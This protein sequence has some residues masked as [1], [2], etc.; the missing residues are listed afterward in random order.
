MKQIAA[1]V[2]TGSDLL[3]DLVNRK[4]TLRRQ[5][6]KDAERKALSLCRRF[7]LDDTVQEEEEE[8]EDSE[9]PERGARGVITQGDRQREYRLDTDEPET[10]E[11]LSKLARE[12]RQ[13]DLSSKIRSMAFQSKFQVHDLDMARL[14]QERLGLPLNITALPQEE[15]RSLQLRRWRLQKAN[16]QDKLNFTLPEMRRQQ[17]KEIEKSVL[18][19][20]DRKAVARVR[21]SR[22]LALT[23]TPRSAPSVA[24]FFEEIQTNPSKSSTLPNSSSLIL[25]SSMHK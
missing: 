5:K 15:D 12:V 18:Q 9:G 24:G 21:R 14:S 25:P 7:L 23:T 11:A 19:A 17:L 8:E 2:S 4:V 20:S 13:A 3:K 1:K 6:D 22:K 16:A 10:A